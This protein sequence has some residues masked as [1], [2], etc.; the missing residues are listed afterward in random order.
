MLSYAVVCHCADAA[1]DALVVDTLGVPVSVAGER[2]MD[3]M[4][5]TQAEPLER[6]SQT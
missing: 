2:R 3:L 4:T 5:L 6:A 1:V